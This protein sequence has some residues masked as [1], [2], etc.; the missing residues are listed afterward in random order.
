MRDVSKKLLSDIFTHTADFI[1]VNQDTVI[2]KD[3]L[4]VEQEISNC[5]KV[6]LNGKNS[7]SRSNFMREAYEKLNFPDYFGYNWSAFS[8][9]LQER[10][11]DDED[12]FE[13]YLLL[14][15]NAD[16]LLSDVM[17]NE[18]EEDISV[19]LEILKDTIEI[20]ADSENVMAIKVVFCLR[21]AVIGS[22]IG[23]SIVNGNHEIQIV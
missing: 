3:L 14:F 23:Q 13:R 8:D 20:M 7:Q 22:R 19:L 5:K 18:E 6:I 11:C 9:S 16:E 21:D 4:E 12:K 15:T 1:L 10:L 17:E 2:A